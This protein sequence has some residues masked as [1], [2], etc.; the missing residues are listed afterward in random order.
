[1][2]FRNTVIILTSNLGTEFL[3]QEGDQAHAGAGDGC[4]AVAFPPRIPQPAGR[5]HPVSIAL[6]A[7]TWTKSWTS[8]RPAR[9]IGWR[10][11]RSRSVWTTRRAIGLGNWPG[12]DPVYGARPLKRVIQRRLQDPLAQMIL[13][14]KIG[15]GAA[16]KVGASKTG[17]TIDGQ[18]L[19]P[20]PTSL[21]MSHRPAWR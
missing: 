16:V 15:E 2:D 13:E 19:R 6:P 1:V 11:A 17:L 10:T 12:Y 9:Q 7:P 14:G 4:G 5:D 20:P 21:W 3:G 8:D 18:E